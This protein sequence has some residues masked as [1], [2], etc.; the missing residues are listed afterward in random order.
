MNLQTYIPN[1]A[2]IPMMLNQKYQH[3]LY[4]NS[5]YTE[6]VRKKMANDG[7]RWLV[8][9]IFC[10]QDHDDDL[11][12]VAVQYWDLKNLDDGSIIFS[13]R[14]GK[15]RELYF[16]HGHTDMAKFKDISFVLYRNILHVRK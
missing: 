3:R 14:D 2:F 5:F 6:G 16:E 11:K 15:G 13:C 9:H 8:D 7:T 4:Q 10:L 1:P 12:K